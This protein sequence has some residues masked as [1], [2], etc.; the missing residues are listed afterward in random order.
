MFFALSLLPIIY[1]MDLQDQINEEEVIMI[2]YGLYKIISR[3]ADAIEKKNTAEGLELLSFDTFELEEM[4]GISSEDWGIA[5]NALSREKVIK[6]VDHCDKEYEEY[7][8]D[9][10]FEKPA[11]HSVTCYRIKVLKSPKSFML[12]LK[13]NLLG[14]NKTKEHQ[15][16]LINKDVTGEFRYNG[17]LMNFKSKTSNSYLVFDFLYKRSK[18][19]ASNHLC[20]YKEIDKYLEENGKRTIKEELG[21][22]D[23]IQNAVGNLITR[24]KIG[25]MTP[26]GERESIESIPGIGLKLYNPPL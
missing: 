17:K 19:D 2:D 8:S 15:P 7:E 16:T 4:E 13:N 25:K 5:L 23:R 26:D 22:R 14:N 12:Y 20:T 3:V 6:I 21:Q 1:T 10:P 18:E 24:G 9:R 11:K